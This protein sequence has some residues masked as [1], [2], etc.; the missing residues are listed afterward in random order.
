MLGAQGRLEGEKLGVMVC[1]D[2]QILTEISLEHYLA[3][4]SSKLP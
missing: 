2:I 1:T 4:R 3:L